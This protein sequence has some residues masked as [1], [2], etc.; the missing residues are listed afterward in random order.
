VQQAPAHIRPTDGLSVRAA[1]RIGW[2]GLIA[3][4][5]VPAIVW[6]RPIEIVASGFEWDFDYLLMGWLGYGLIAAGV[7][8]MVPVVVSIGRTPASR[9]YPRSRNSLVGW[10]V[11][12][13]VMGAGIA[14]QVAQIA[15]GLS[16]A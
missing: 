1:R 4:A 12:L 7:L 16:E 8:L 14:A 6:R 10:S 5:A 9:L 3:A 13:Y 2:A 15:M 11:S